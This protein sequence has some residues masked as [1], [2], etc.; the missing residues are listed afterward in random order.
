MILMYIS[1]FMK[2][3]INNSNTF[4]SYYNL[5]DKYFAHVLWLT[6]YMPYTEKL[7]TLSRWTYSLSNYI[8]LYQEKL[9]YFGDLRNQLVHGFRLDNNHYVLASD[10]AVHEIQVL[11]EEAR[12]PTS[13]ADV[14]SRKVYICHTH[15]YLSEVICS[16]REHLNT[17]IPVYTSDGAFVEMLSESTIAYRI[18]EEIWDDGEIHLAEVKVADV[19]LEN[20]N[21]LFVFVWEKTSIYDIE[22]MFALNIKEKKRLGAVFITQTWKPEEDIVWIITAMDLPV[23]ANHFVL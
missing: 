10:H 6:K 5:L 3:S 1:S 17:H 4:L 23:L 9:R 2:H 13:V 11:Y 20:S 19:T 14:F 7:S 22:Q 18:A 15:D 12:E 21:D 16:M 8:R